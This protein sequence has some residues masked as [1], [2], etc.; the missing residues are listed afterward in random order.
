MRLSVDSESN[1]VF[2]KLTHV[3]L[4]TVVNLAVRNVR[5]QAGQDRRE[6]RLYGT[7][8]PP[9]VRN[10]DERYY[11]RI[12]PNWAHILNRFDFTFIR[13]TSGARYTVN[14]TTKTRKEDYGSE[15]AE[16]TTSAYLYTSK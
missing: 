14:V 6:D 13:L 4:P 7:F 16:Y 1:I 11:V 10:G 3:E 15:T 5:H 8:D 12:S 9:T 2:L